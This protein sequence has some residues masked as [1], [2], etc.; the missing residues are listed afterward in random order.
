MTEEY[1]TIQNREARVGDQWRYEGSLT[2]HDIEDAKDVDFVNRYFL[3]CYV[4][5]KKPTA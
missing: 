1:E 4:R 3:Q 2:W 5:R